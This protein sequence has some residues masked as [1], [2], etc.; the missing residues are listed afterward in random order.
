MHHTIL[1]FVAIRLYNVFQFTYRHIARLIGIPKTTIHR[2][3]TRDPTCK[4]ISCS[5]NKS[6]LDTIRKTIHDIVI[7]NPCGT[8][9]QYVDQLPFKMSVSTMRYHLNALRFSCKKT[10]PIGIVNMEAVNIKRKEFIETMLYVD[11]KDVI[12]LDESSLYKRLNP[13]RGWSPVGRRINVP[14]QRRMSKRYTLTAAISDSGVVHH[15]LITGSSNMQHFL[16]FIKQLDKVPQKYVMLDNVAFH[17]TKAVMAEFARLKKVPIFVA[18]YSPDWNPVE[19]YF[20][21]LKSRIRKMGVCDDL[22][23]SIRQCNTS[24]NIDSFKRIFASVFKNIKNN[25]HR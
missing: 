18:P 25:H 20:W 5:H 14:M 8:L 9:Q 23:E 11:V 7:A 1:H 15:Q 10:H 6:Q 12:S 21:M 16:S 24:M 2:W 4:K 19:T 17:K 22:A 13:H 3:I